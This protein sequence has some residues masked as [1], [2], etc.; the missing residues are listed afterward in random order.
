VKDAR[1]ARQR[2]VGEAGNTQHGPRQHQAKVRPERGLAERPHQ[3]RDGAP[4]A[5]VREAREDRGRE[6]AARRGPP[7][8]SV[9]QG[10]RGG[11]R[12]QRVRGVATPRDDPPRRHAAEDVGAC[13]LPGVD[14]LP[15]RA[16][17]SNN[18]DRHR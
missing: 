5:A 11:A 9:R 15:R 2:A 10:Q 8:Q 18:A 7:E 16:P 4:G 1:A 13:V 12:G 3:Q 6:E 14:V 17:R